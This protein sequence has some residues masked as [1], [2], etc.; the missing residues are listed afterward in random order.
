MK[1]NSWHDKYVYNKANESREHLLRIKQLEDELW[2][3]RQ[4]NLFREENK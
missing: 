4:L 3:E 2:L 1:P